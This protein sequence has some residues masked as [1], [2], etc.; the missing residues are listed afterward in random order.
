MRL[1]GDFEEAGWAPFSTGTSDVTPG[2]S[3]QKEC[4]GTDG[5]MLHPGPDAF[6]C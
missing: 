2:E 4:C 3:G 1:S 6:T 5:H